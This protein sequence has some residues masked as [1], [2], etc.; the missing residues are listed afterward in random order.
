METLAESALLAA[1]KPSARA[2]KPTARSRLSNGNGVLPH[3]DGRSQIVRRYRD[4]VAAVT[5]DLGGP[6]LTEAKLQLVRRLA[7]ICVLC[8]ETESKLAN[9]ADIDISEYAQLTST[10][11]RVSSRLGLGRMPKDVTLINPLDYAASIRERGSVP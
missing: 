5:A 10:L 8:E 11:V 1:Q 9:G 6:D 4:I 3:A 7:G 2:R